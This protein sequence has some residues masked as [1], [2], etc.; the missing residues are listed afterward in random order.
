MVDAHLAD[1]QTAIINLG[2]RNEE[3]PGL[4]GP[5]PVH[6]EQPRKAHGSNKLQHQHGPHSPLESCVLARWSFVQRK[7]LEAAARHPQKK[8]AV[9]PDNLKGGAR[10]KVLTMNWFN[11]NPIPWEW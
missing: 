1:T 7:L 6:Q 4:V 2:C 10:I 5:G 8:L 9:F 11:S 3:A